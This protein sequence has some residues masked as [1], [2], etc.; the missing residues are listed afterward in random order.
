MAEY[1]GIH[2]T[3]IQNYTTDPDNPITG[4][5]WYNETS[6]TMKF[7]Y[8]TVINSWS[9]G[10]NMNTARRGM[11]SAQYGTQSAAL[12]AGGNFPDK[13]NTESYNG[14]A[15]TEV[16]D[17]NTARG[18]F[19]GAGTQTL[20]LAF[21]GDPN[22]AL[23]ESWNG[24]S[25]TEVNDLNQGRNG[26]GGAGVDNTSALCFGG[27]DFGTN[28]ETWNGTSWTEVNDLNTFRR[29]QGWGTQTSAIAVAGSSD[30]LPTPPKNVAVTESWNG[31]SWTEVNDLNAA[32][33]S[34]GTAGTDNTSG[35]A[36]G[37]S[38]TTGATEIWNGTSWSE[39][40]DLNTARSNVSGAGTSSS[41]LA[42]GGYDTSLLTATEEWTG[43]GSPLTVTFTDS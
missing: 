31:T 17:L 14:S 34:I 29:T 23:T 41:A 9:T 21:G 19:A 36:F 3:K 24:T 37:G 28:V 39:D 13:A 18:S 4:Q 35:L 1:K 32:R 25:W 42:F 11:A 38:P 22:V 26:I 15:W 16:N 2:G 12:G 7:Q 27:Q 10:G 30:P 33:S 20:A 8:P 6:Q 40:T 5:V 43:A